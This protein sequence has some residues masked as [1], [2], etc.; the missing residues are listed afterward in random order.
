MFRKSKLLSLVCVTLLFLTIFHIG[1]SPIL[2]LSAETKSEESNTDTF[3]V[4]PANRW[5]EL[6]GGVS[7]SVDGSLLVL[8][9]TGDGSSDYYA[10]RRELRDLEGTV[11]TRFMYETNSDDTHESDQIVI[12]FRA[13]SAT[14]FQLRIDNIKDQEN[15]TTK[16]IYWDVD[17]GSQTKT[18]ADSEELWDDYWYKVRFDYDYLHSTFRFRAYFDNNTEVFDYIWQ[19]IGSIT[20][21]GFE[22]PSQLGIRIIHYTRTSSKVLTSYWDYVEAPFKD[23]EW[24]K[25]D[26]PTDTDWIVEA[27]D[28]A[29]G[30]AVSSDTMKWELTIPYLD[31]YAGTLFIDVNDTLEAGEFAYILAAV[32][33]VTAS[34]GAQVLLIYAALMVENIGGTGDK[35]HGYLAYSPSDTVHQEYKVTQD[36]STANPRLGFSFVTQDSRSVIEGKISFWADYQS[37]NEDNYQDSSYTYSAGTDYNEFVVSLKYAVGNLDSGEYFI[38]GADG[39]SIVERQVFGNRGQ[40]LPG[41]GGGLLGQLSLDWFLL[42]FTW[43]G[44]LLNTAIKGL[45]EF[46]EDPLGAIENSIGALI[47]DFFDLLWTLG[48]DLADFLI[49]DLFFPLLWDSWGGP[50]ILAWV[51]WGLTGIILFLEGGLEWVQDVTTQLQTIW[52]LLSLIGLIVFFGFPLFYASS[53]GIYLDKMFDYMGF[54]ITFGLLSSLLPRI[55]AVLVWLVVLQVDILDGT[56]L[57]GFLTW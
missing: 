25:T 47:V 1:N 56:A 8:S 14:D 18:L 17:S 52:G 10:I 35:T 6:S 55:P 7:A 4:H 44:N 36:H 50:D 3:D 37:G 20:P 48:S 22:R 40:P 38:L 24:V 26:D 19:Q 53:I 57:G 39:L 33:G 31:S 45:G 41:T 29:E 28:R 13:D 51:E 11:W 34:T 12:E 15:D 43:L 49:D 32:H 54:D 27:V 46:L 23:R 30:D 9:D 5:S 2:P 21:I 42:P 16:L